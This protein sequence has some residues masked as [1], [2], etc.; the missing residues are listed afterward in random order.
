MWYTIGHAIDYES[1][2]ISKWGKNA[3]PHD[4]LTLAPWVDEVRAY[5][6]GCQKDGHYWYY[7]EHAVKCLIIWLPNLVP[8]DM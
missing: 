7:V 8:D 3:Q 6:I 1:K 2:G 5:N 4:P